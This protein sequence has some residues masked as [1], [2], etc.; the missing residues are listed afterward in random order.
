MRNRLLVP[1][2]ALAVA[3]VPV[4]AVWAAAPAQADDDDP[5]SVVQLCAA[6]SIETVD[7]YLANIA[8]TRLVADLAPLVE[9]TVPRTNTG[10]KV[11]GDV[12]LEQIRDA[13]NCTDPPTTT[14]TTTTKT[15]APDDDDSDDDA[16]TTTP[17]RAPTPKVVG[18]DLHVTG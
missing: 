3:A 18:G 12:S 10:V 11:E 16:V 1:L 17:P 14:T 8:E 2:A 4:A 9:L 5:P 15:T 7:A 6:T 13:L